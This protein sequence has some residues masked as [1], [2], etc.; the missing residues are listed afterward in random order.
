MVKI[1]K[2][3]VNGKDH[4]IKLMS[5]GEIVGHRSLIN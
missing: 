5:K 1:S 2:L 4:I 3:G